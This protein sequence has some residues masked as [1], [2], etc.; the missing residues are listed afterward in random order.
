ML[1]YTQRYILQPVSMVQS[2]RT[3]RQEAEELS[4]AIKQST[5]VQEQRKNQQLQRQV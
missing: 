5:H 4:T 2:P 3:T 1:F